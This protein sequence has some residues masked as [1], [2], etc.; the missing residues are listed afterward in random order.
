MKA[1]EVTWEEAMM[2]GV[3]EQPL[4]AAGEESMPEAPVGATS[5]GRADE[6]VQVVEVHCLGRSKYC[7]D[8]RE[9]ELRYDRC[10]S[11]SYCSPGI[12][13]KLA[14]FAQR[15][16]SSMSHLSRSRGQWSCTIASLAY[17]EISHPI[18]ASS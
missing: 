13:L 3:S 1:D 6:Q 11:R 7:N 4:P 10:V 8:D 14:R 9:L 15:E 5:H 12:H 18:F 17:T 2:L 16:S